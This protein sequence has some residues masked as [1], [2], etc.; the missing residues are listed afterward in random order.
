MTEDLPPDR[1]AS[2]GDSPTAAELPDAVAA[3]RI[4]V[5]IGD[6][7]PEHCEA[8]L[9]LAA[10]MLQERAAVLHLVHGCTPRFAIAPTSGAVER[11]LA[12]G[13]Q[14][15]DEAQ[16]A[17]SSILDQNTP[18]TLTALPQTGIDA[19]LQ[20]SNQAAVVIVQRRSG[21]SIRR[22]YSGLTSATV[23]AQAACPVIVVRH[24][25]SGTDSTSG[26]VVGVTPD[27]GLRALEVGIVEAAARNCPL[28]AVHVWD[29]QFSPTFG[30]S[31]DPDGEELAEA[32]RWAD[33]V[34]ARAV[35]PVV[36]DHHDVEVRA[37]SIRGVVQN[38]LLQECEHAE[39][40]VVERHRDTQLASIGL[41][42]LTRHLIDHAPCPVMITPRSDIRDQAEAGQQTE[43]DPAGNAKE[44]VI[45]D[46]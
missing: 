29:L 42:A 23:A 39:L 4:V 40:L 20:E 7:G 21:S 38:A 45:D 35:A 19:L 1:N 5:G 17:L 26:V 18:I 11:H 34:L 13:R 37:L 22:I 8:A 14:L 46:R 41:G 31:I 9:A 33:L 44:G 30:G 16:L 15:L 10:Q 6:S 25:Q 43:P 36:K 2:P 28:T 3:S 32:T 27:S 24:D 12:R